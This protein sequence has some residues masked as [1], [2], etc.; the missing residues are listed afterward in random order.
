[1]EAQKAPH[2]LI[3]ACIQVLPKLPHLHLLMVG[4]GPEREKLQTRMRAERLEHRATW[5]GAVDGVQFMPA[6]DMLAVSSVYEG[7]AYVLLE[8]LNAGLPIVTTPVGGVHESVICGKNGI[9]VAH[10]PVHPLADALYQ[11]GRDADRR[12]AMGRAS[13]E[14][15]TQFSLSRMI[16][17]LERLYYR[18][19]KT[20]VR[21]A[22]GNIAALADPAATIRRV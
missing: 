21:P 19:L 5:L 13:R 3:E 12:R 1:L 8:A 9:I 14:H 17:A 7:F 20:S 15:A 4:D 2:R 16:D 18:S 6:M 11:L 22:P 10:Q